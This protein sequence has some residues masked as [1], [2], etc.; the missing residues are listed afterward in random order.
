MDQSGYAW[1]IAYTLR[2]AITSNV[3]HDA[4]GMNSKLINWK[5][6]GRGATSCV[7][8]LPAMLCRVIAV[9]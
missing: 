8:L 7:L 5:G 9:V 6:G 3:M 1:V 4:N 2:R